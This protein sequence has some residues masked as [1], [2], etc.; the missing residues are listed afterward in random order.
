VEKGC[1]DEVKDGKVQFSHGAGDY[2]GEAAF[3]NKANHEIECVAKVDC[4]LLTLNEYSFNVDLAPV[5]KQIKS[6][7]SRY[8]KVGG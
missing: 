4:F 6:N 1:V 3:L 5:L 7:Q 2:F 8:K